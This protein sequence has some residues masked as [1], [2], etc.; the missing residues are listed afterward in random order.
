MKKKTI[1]LFLPLLLSLFLIY[2]PKEN[3]ETKVIEIIDYGDSDDEIIT[4]RNLVSYFDTM[5]P[6]P[7]FTFEKQNTLKCECPNEQTD[8]I[9]EEIVRPLVT[10]AHADI[11]WYY[12][13]ELGY[14]KFVCAGILGNIMAEVGGNSFRLDPFLIEAANGNYYGICQWSR[15]YSEIWYADLDT[16]L[17]FLRDTIE[18][19]F[20]VFGRLYK[21]GFTYSDF[22]ELQDETEAALAFAKVYERCA[23]W[24][25]PYREE[26]ATVALNYFGY[27]Y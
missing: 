13:K 27:G 3:K 23:E 14:N 11:I 15:G 20:A 4:R 17:N 12:L 18:Y 7:I 10:Y 24:T 9:P 2:L 6:E 25:Y 5:C 1:W 21:E 26:N 16:Q 19:E 8:P 22:L